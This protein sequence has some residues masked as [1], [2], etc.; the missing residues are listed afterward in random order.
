MS[1][2]SL[3]TN[4]SFQ[5]QTSNQQTN[6]MIYE[7]KSLPTN[8]DDIEENNSIID[9]TSYLKAPDSFYQT[10]YLEDSN[11]VFSPSRQPRLVDRIPLWPFKQPPQ[12]EVKRRKMRIVDRNPE[13]GQSSGN[14][15]VRKRI[16]KKEWWTLY[17][18]DW[19]HSLINTPTYRIILILLGAYLLLIFIFAWIFYHLSCLYQ[20]QL[21][22]HS[23]QDAFVF[24]LET[25]A[26]I[27]YGTQDIF[28]DG[29]QSVVITLTILM[30]IKLL[31]EGIT[32]GI[33]Y[34][35]LSRPHS[36]AT[37]LIFTDK[38]IMR[39]I[40]GKLYFMFQLCELR[41]HQLVEA[42]IRLYVLKKEIDPSAIQSSSSSS[43]YSY[44]QTCSMRL[45]HPN[46]ELGGMLLL[47]LPQVIVHELDAT[48]P[49]MPPPI[50]IKNKTK[51]IIRWNPPSYKSFQVNN[52]IYSSNNTIN[53]NTTWPDVMN[54]NA[55]NQYPL[56][57]RQGQKDLENNG[58]ID[59]DE[60]EVNVYDNN[61]MNITEELSNYDIEMLSNLEFPNVYK[62]ASDHR[63]LSNNEINSPLPS[64]ISTNTSYINNSTNTNQLQSM[65]LTLK[66][67][68]RST[69]RPSNNYNNIN[70]TNNS[71]L[72]NVKIED[73]F[74]SPGFKQYS[75]DLLLPKSKIT[76]KPMTATLNNHSHLTNPSVS[77]RTIPLK[78]PFQTQNMQNTTNYTQANTQAN[79][80][81]LNNQSEFIPDWQHEE[82]N[83]IQMYLEDREI[84]ILAIVE[85]IDS[86]TGGN[87]QA[88]HSYLS[89]E[90]F[91]HKQFEYCLFQDPDDHFLTVDFDKFQHL[92]DVSK[93]SP[94]PGPISSNI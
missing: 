9:E 66:T 51:E 47:M 64:N 14:I 85:G 91:W 49:L 2:K 25:I 86:S 6:E 12:P 43:S 72:S 60:E 35:R 93:D 62:R 27:G 5:K 53:T 19:F 92:A 7:M 28:F 71:N 45:N 58:E 74:T 46:D 29:C 88:R 67:P 42:H 39:R 50:W 68:P 61:T 15:Y 16:K 84:E 81:Q 59:D 57:Q 75:M 22:F 31:V 83:M 89:S 1:Y 20:C 73:T 56:S 63:R 55:F 87:V 17:G 4:D 30:C 78:L 44:I 65:N 40:R 41:K 80:N 48:S 69:I 10:N 23:F 26:T 70:N 3:S 8:T 38:A 21:G 18:S 32:I 24:T 77:N 82:N 90:I 54:M 33:I 76:P 34:A 94:Y 13:T 36:R 79:T 11:F 52:N 37:T